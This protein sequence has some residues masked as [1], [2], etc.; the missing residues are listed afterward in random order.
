MIEPRDTVVM[1]KASRPENG[2]GPKITWEPL[3]ATSSDNVDAS[4][5]NE[6][7]ICPKE[8]GCCTKYVSSV[9]GKEGLMHVPKV[10]SQIS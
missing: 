7:I 1:V 8:Q 2:G 9:F 6:V 10:L 4:S 3:E 5:D